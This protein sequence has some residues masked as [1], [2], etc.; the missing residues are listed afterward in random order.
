MTCQPSERFT[1]SIR[2]GPCDEL[3]FGLRALDD[4]DANA[5][6][7]RIMA[8]LNVADDAYVELTRAPSG[9]TVCSAD[10]PYRNCRFS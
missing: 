3:R 1:L 9:I 10:R 4:S 8:R 7:T 6:T 2:T 5:K